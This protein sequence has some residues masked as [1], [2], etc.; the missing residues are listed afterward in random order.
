MIRTKFTAFLA[1]AV[2]VLALPGLA[3]ALDSGSSTVTVDVG[4]HAVIDVQQQPVDFGT[5]LGAPGIYYNDGSQLLNHVQGVWGSQ[6]PVH[7]VGLPQTQNLGIIVVTA[8]GNVNVDFEFVPG[9]NWLVSESIFGVWNRWGSQ[10]YF[11]RFFGTEPGHPMNITTGQPYIEAGR[12]DGQQR[13]EL[14]GSFLIEYIS[15]QPAGTYTAE[16]LITVTP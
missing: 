13:Y 14:V 15:Q 7:W 8:N 4:L 9:N 1:I 3:S 12:P 11:G 6:W 5:V 2:L 16:I 10:G